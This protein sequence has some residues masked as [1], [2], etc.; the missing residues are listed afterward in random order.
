MRNMKRLNIINKMIFIII[1]IFFSISYS[2]PYV[3]LRA[4]INSHNEINPGFIPYYSNE[5]LVLTYHVLD[6]KVKG[7][8]SISPQLFEEH[9]R[10]LK[11]AGFHPITPETLRE[12]ME[13]KTDIPDNAVLITFDD[14]Y[15]SFYKLAYPILEKYRVPA[16]NFIIVSMVGKVGAFP[17][18][19]WN[20][21]KEMLKSNL[22]Y[23][24]SHTYDS[25]HLVRTGLFSQ[26]PALVGHIYKPLFYRESDEEYKS[27]I[28][29]DLWYSKYLLEKNLNIEVKD[30]CF[31][32]G[33]YNST[34]LEIA[35]ELGYEVFYTT[36]KG[37]NKPGKDKYIIIKR[38]N[39]GSY[40][41]SLT[42]FQ[43]M[44]FKYII[45][46]HP[47]IHTNKFIKNSFKHHKKMR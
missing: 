44:L 10:Y 14:G 42:R 9:I 24:G 12:F 37:I 17:H 40:N 25:H 26:A 20:E 30:L 3:E 18:L 22:I 47:Q 11:N 23:F 21:M 15:E 38:L 5:V 33:A 39:A 6:K 4:D 7:P 46:S 27:R 36:N 8:I 1:L 32:Y 29:G 16:I 41:M 28:S 35:K 2:Y 13:G 31:P 45:L 43:S 34:V 19:T